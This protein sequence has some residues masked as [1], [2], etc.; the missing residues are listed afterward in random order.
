MK[1]FHCK[2]LFVCLLKGCVCIFLGL[3]KWPR[4]PVLDGRSD[5]RRFQTA[6][7]YRYVIDFD[8]MSTILG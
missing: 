3:R 2:N 5:G 1:I 7:Q 4:D 8:G 6:C